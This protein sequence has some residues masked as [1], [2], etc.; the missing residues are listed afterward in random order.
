[1]SR[2]SGF[3]KPTGRWRD[4][5]SWYVVCLLCAGLGVAAALVYVFAPSFYSLPVFICPIHFLT[6][7]YCPGC[8]GSRAFFLLLHTDIIG[9]A[10]HN[11]A[12]TY[13]IIVGALYFISQTAHRLGARRLPL[14]RHR[15]YRLVIMG[16][17]FII[18]CIVK[19]AALLIWGVRLIN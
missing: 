7:Y 12:V 10:V 16:A 14:M 4:D 13:G 2:A 17:L 3:F 18:N 6:G 11:A 9:S 1:M 19:N 5:D 15:T 8:G